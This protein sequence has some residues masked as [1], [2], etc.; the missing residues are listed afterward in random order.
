[1]NAF[2]IGRL[3]GI[4]VRVDYSWLLIFVLLTWNL[5]AVFGGWH[6]AWPAAETFGVAVGA[7][8]LFFVCILLHELAHSLVATRYGLRVRSITLFLFG[9][10]SNIEHEPPQPRVEFF[11]AI[12]GPVASILLGLGFL[13]VSLALMPVALDDASVARQTLAALGPVAT[14]LAW[15]GPINLVIGFFN[16]V[17]AF[18]LDGGR[19]LRSILWATSG[20]LR[21][22]TRRASTVGQGFGWLLIAVGLAM[23]FGA[24]LPFFGTGLVAG[25][26]LAFIGWFLHNAALQSYRR[27]AVDD[28]LAGH[29]VEEIMRRS[30][31]SVGPDMRLDALVHDYLLRSDSE[32]FPVV[33][34]G[35]LV[36]VVAFADVRRVPQQEWAATP[37]AQVMRAGARLPIAK[38]DE[39]LV[40][41]FEELARRDVGQLPVLDHGELVGM[42]LRSDVA[43]WLDLTWQPRRPDPAR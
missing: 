14:L 6:P 36:G 30:G 39:P 12:V 27:L 13:L 37:V 38:P 24:R 17:P 35:H 31:P 5:V 4:D 10:V 26:W 40:E 43:R 11:T 42:L 22:S 15:L 18:P 16:L 19:V 32:A 25:L 1:M 41:A 20:D 2:R 8:V 28:A 9:G 3:S 33:R 21:L 23:A 34:Q 29:R 7:S